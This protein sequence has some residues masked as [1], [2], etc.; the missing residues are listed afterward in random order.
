MGKR[1]NTLKILSYDLGWRFLSKRSL[2]GH[3]ESI[4][5]IK[6]GWKY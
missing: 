4:T 5:D 1:L 6:Y 2:R 3:P